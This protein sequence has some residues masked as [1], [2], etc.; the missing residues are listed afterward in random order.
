MGSRELE[1]CSPFVCLKKLVGHSFC[2]PYCLAWQV[3]MQQGEPYVQ[4]IDRLRGNPVTEDIATARRSFGDVSHDVQE[5][6]KQAKVAPMGPKPDPWSTTLD[7]SDRSGCTLGLSS[8]GG[9]QTSMDLEA[10]YSDTTEMDILIKAGSRKAAMAMIHRLL[11]NAIDFA[12]RAYGIQE[13]AH[14][15][16]EP[17]LQCYFPQQAHPVVQIHNLSAH[18]CAASLQSKC[19][20]KADQ[21]TY[22]REFLCTCVVYFVNDRG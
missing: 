21:T 17:I 12:F 9:S 22:H 5:H 3:A 6:T 8:N 16:L 13:S 14:M 4:W 20:R 10:A 7:E 1:R 19:R 18:A 11:A 15:L 2:I